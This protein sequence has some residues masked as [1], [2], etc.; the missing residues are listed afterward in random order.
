M[1][2]PVES[3]SPG[4]AAL[5]GHD[6]DM[7]PEPG[8]NGLKVDGTPN[9]IQ[10]RNGHTKEKTRGVGQDAQHLPSP[11]PT[12]SPRGVSSLRLTS[13]SLAE[14]TGTPSS[15]STRRRYSGTY[16]KPAMHYEA[17]SKGKNDASPQTLSISKSD[18]HNVSGEKTRKPKALVIPKMNGDDK[19]FKLTA[20]EMEEL[21]SAPDSLP[22]SSLRS[23]G[24]LG[25]TPPPLAPSPVLEKRSHYGANEDEG[26]DQARS[27]TDSM[28]VATRANL[29][30]H[31]TEGSTPMSVVSRRPGISSRRISS[32]QIA[33]NR[34]PSYTR[35]SYGHTSPRRRSGLSGSRPEQLDFTQ[36]KSAAG[37]KKSSSLDP[38]PSPIPQSI[39]LPPMSIPT[40]LQLELSSSKP[41]PLY[42]YRSSTS[43]DIYESSKIKFER[44]LNFLLLPPQ[45]EQILYFGTLACL[46]AWLHTF[47]ILPLRFLKAITI[48]IQWWGQTLNK[49]IRFIGGFIYHGSG[50]MW[51]RQ[52]GRAPSH[53]TPPRSRSE[54]VPR[55]R[56][57]QLSTPLPHPQSAR[58]DI[59]NG[60]TAVD[61]IKAETERKSRQGWGPRHRRVKSQPSS[62]LSSH[63]ADLLQGAVIICS[64]IILMKFDASRM[65]HSIRG[66]AAIKLYVIYN[67]LE[68]RYMLFR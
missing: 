18:R 67:V 11:S 62:L 38:P 15:L 12:P 31:A 40:Y 45:L 53:E 54:S 5:E 37:G 32:P 47:T 63:K 4:G 39:P 35:D 33:R 65:Y 16:E 21:T 48:L 2:V 27:S 50:R 55:S 30:H 34:G 17:S 23:P 52:R 49:E 41:S 56:R 14:L 7:R 22:R 6:N 64:C 28:Y 57:P 42:I 51:H 13:D 1:P 10:K 3:R 46:D 36:S 29:D 8:N 25:S 61:S 68:V 20:A 60:S 58:P 44:L 9:T 59:A 19:I 66:Q 24:L 43:E 26:G